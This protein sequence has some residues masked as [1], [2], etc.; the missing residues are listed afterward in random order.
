M[1][2]K[3]SQQASYGELETAQENI[4]G[5]VDMGA[6][7]LYKRALAATSCGIVISDARQPDIPVIY[8]NPAFEKITGY[9][10]EEIIGQKLPVFTRSRY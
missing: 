8:C 5:Q 1:N 2:L 9:S 6:F 10:Q 7:W 4:V 3:A